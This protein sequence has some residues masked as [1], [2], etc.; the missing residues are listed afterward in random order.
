MRRAV[1]QPQRRTYFNNPLIADSLQHLPAAVDYPTS[2]A[3]RAHLIETLHHNSLTTRRRFAQYIAQR[4]SH[5]GVMNR[6]LA[7]ALRKFGDSRSG[8]EILYFE[9]IRAVPLLQEIASLWLAELPATGAPRSRLEGFLAARLAG[10]STEKVVQASLQA[11][12]ECG[13]MTSPKPG[14]CIPVWTEPPLEAFLYALAQ[15][16]PEQTMVRVEM[17]ANQPVVRAMLWPRPAVEALLRAAEQAGHVSKISAL[18]QYHQFTLAGTGE[19]RMAR[20]LA[21]PPATETV[22][23]GTADYNKQPRRVAKK[24]SAK[25]AGRSSRRSKPVQLTLPGTCR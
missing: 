4:F 9:L 13:K 17:F 21:S 7:L 25:T 10:R 15:L 22:R 8:R 11:F 16:C 23:E 3:F 20:L 14:F 5:D 2:V 6:D 18:D 19:E 12:R 1:S 24:A